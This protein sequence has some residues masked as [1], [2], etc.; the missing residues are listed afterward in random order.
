MKNIVASPL[1]YTG[2]KYKLLPQILPL[3]PEHIG[4]F[5]DMFCGGCNVG[6]NINTAGEDDIT[7]DMVIYNDI[8]VSL[9]KIIRTIK[10]V[11][12]EN[13]ICQIE[14]IIKEYG[15]SDTKHNG[16]DNY[17]SNSA[18]GLGRYNKE[19]YMRLRS[20][21][22][23][24]RKTKTY[25]IKLYVLIIFAFN[26]QIRFNANGEFNLPVGKR[27]FNA[28]MEM[29]LKSFSDTLRIQHCDFE[30]KSFE[31]YRI[32]DFNSNDFI[33]CDPPYLITTAAYN[34]NGGW[35]KDDEVKLLDFLSSL[36]KAGI[37]FALSNVLEHKGRVNTI[38]TEWAKDY[39]IHHLNYNYHNSNYHS[40]NTE[41]QTDEVL[42]T[43]Y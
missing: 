31:D 18:D 42:I 25:Y 20:D 39:N 15:L 6:I 1:N 2:G 34:E 27:D 13:L 22:N 3:F 35:T 21:V 19:A 43:N 10:S 5:Y 32:T 17:R 7:A 9:L 41:K 4:T 14:S 24:M 16:Y 11:P 33:Y 40:R 12:A 23:S 37:K 8:N 29:K 30:N 26:N 38:L 36:D 28:K